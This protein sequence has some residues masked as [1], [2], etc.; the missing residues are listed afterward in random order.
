MIIV[1][2]SDI[3]DT[4]L[5]DVELFT[6]RILLYVAP[7]HMLHNRERVAP[8]DLQDGDIWV[9][10]SFHDRY[11]QLSEFTHRESMH[12]AFLDTGSLSTLISLVD[13]NGGYT[14]IPQL[15]A[16]AL[17]E[18]QRQNI[19]IIQSPKFFRTISLAFRRDYLRERMLNIVADI[20]KHIVPDD[21]I[22]DQIKKY[23]ITI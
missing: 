5:L 13:I 12:T 11:Q 1:S 14:L 15:Y 22:K 17:N 20:I 9:L 18:Q 8:E 2:S 16:N 6:E 10:K 21:M 4:N 23:K 19:R 7:A 3:K